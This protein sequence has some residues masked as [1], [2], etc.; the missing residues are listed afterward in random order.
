MS[1]TL[2]SPGPT[3]IL[4]TTAQSTGDW[5]R[6]HPKMGKLTFQVVHTGTSDGS[7]VGST[8]VIE[9]SND[10]VHALATP[11]GTVALSSNSGTNDGFTVDAN[12]AFVRAR[13]GSLAAATAGSTAPGDYNLSVSVAGQW[14]S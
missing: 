13:V 8:T 5:Y 12:W 11:L 9:A 4:S 3:N 6:V 2:N 1:Y 7:S 10:G 14:R